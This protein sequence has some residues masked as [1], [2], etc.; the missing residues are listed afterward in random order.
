MAAAAG[1]DPPGPVDELEGD[2]AVAEGPEE[3]LDE[4]AAPLAAQEVRS[5]Q[6]RALAGSALELLPSWKAGGPGCHLFTCVVAAPDAR[7]CNEQAELVKL[8]ILKAGV[9]GGAVADSGAVRPRWRMGGRGGGGAWT[10]RR[11]PRRAPVVRR[12]HAAAPRALLTPP[13]APF[14]RLPPAGGGRPLGFRV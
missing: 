4:A 5:D 1:N 10:G 14:P 11:A 13:P 8:L 7:R 9:R 2:E 6:A 3:G 12:P